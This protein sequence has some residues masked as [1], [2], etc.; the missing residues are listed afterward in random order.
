MRLWKHLFVQVN[1][2]LS[3]F[4]RRNL[5]SNS[6]RLAETLNIYWNCIFYTQVK[7]IYVKNLPENVSWQDQELFDKH[8]EVTKKRTSTCRGCISFVHFAERSS[9]LYLW[10][11][12]AGYL[13]PEVWLGL[14]RAMAL[15]LQKTE[16]NKPWA[17]FLIQS[18][19]CVLSIFFL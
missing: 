4:M 13:G 7:T 8:G 15:W 5:H 14:A 1:L 9:L 18:C 6:F 11:C 17:A 12:Q 16:P 3:S 19:S 10:A 2:G